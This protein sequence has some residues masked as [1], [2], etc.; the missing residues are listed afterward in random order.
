MRVSRKLRRRTDYV[1][2]YILPIQ[3]LLIRGSLCE[4]DSWSFGELFNPP[5]GAE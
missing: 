4:N 5:A 1:T 2:D 3:E